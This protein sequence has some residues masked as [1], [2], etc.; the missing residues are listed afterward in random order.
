MRIYL[1]FLICLKALYLCRELL[2]TFKSLTTL[3]LDPSHDLFLKNYDHTCLWKV[4][5]SLL[6]NA[7]NLEVLI[8]DQV[9][10]ELFSY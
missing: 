4:L 2:P 5:P 8:F 3:S 10:C 9:S 7:P 6:K 1:L